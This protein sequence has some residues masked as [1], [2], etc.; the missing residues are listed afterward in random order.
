[1]QVRIAYRA[2]FQSKLRPIPGLVIAVAATAAVAAESRR[3]H[4]GLY[5]FVTA[6][7]TGVQ[8]V[9]TI[10]SHILGLLQLVTLTSIINLSTRL[11]LSRGSVSLA[12]LRLWQSIAS[13]QIAWTMPVRHI[14]IA[15]L[16]II[17]HLLPSALWTGAIT[18]ISSTASVLGSIQIPVYAPD[19]QSQF[20]NHSSTATISDFLWPVTRNARGAFSY[21]PAPVLQGVILNSAST[22][23]SRADGHPKN[24][25][26]RLTYVGRSFGVGSTAG[27][28]DGF[29][30]ILSAASSNTTSS[31]LSYSYQETGYSTTVSCARNASSLWTIVT[32]NI[33]MGDILP[34][35]PTTSLISVEDYATVGLRNDSQIV[36]LVGLSHPP[37]NIFAFATG[38]GP[39]N[40]LNQVQCEV[41]FNP[42]KFDVSVNM[43]SRAINVTLLPESSV[44]DMDP[45]SSQFGVGLGSIAQLTMR[46]VTFLSMM[47]TNLYTSALG[48][49]FMTSIENLATEHSTAVN[50]TDTVMA[51]VAA[52][53]ESMIDDVLV[54]IGSAQLEIGALSSSSMITAV[55][56]QQILPAMRIGERRYIAAIGALNALVLCI[57]LVELWRTR[58]WLALPVFD[59]NDLPTVVM[60]ASRGR[61]GGEKMGDGLYFPDSSADTRIALVDLGGMPALTQEREIGTLTG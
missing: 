33:S 43:T 7:R 26:S 44:E 28:G 45:T 14:I 38:D 49:V 55:S 2:T 12:E 10:I 35:N 47:N 16:Y 61:D 27:L 41:Q 25:N 23:T 1:M 13:A 32:H 54:G 15:G 18:P 9:I 30:D 42:S 34:I 37:S 6:H 52:S 46:Q 53:L 51:A 60:A 3:D 20:W 48:T 40:V 19:P 24:D 22:A 56:T 8:V 17:V 4:T 36:A 5:S 58:G 57:F 29:F 31:V 21:T 59:Y 39:Y 11:R 50:D